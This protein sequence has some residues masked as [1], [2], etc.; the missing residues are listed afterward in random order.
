MKWNELKDGQKV[1][2]QQELLYVDDEKASG[3]GY[4]TR[5][6]VNALITVVFPAG[7]ELTYISE[8]GSGQMAGLYHENGDIT[9]GPITE[10]VDPEVYL[11]ILD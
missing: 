1:V 4:M 5:A 7:T 8:E 9:V 10:E 2:L 3:Y 6:E 11:V